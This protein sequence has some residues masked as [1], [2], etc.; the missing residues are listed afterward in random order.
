[1]TKYKG[2]HKAGRST[3]RNLANGSRVDIPDEEVLPGDEKTTYIKVR[4]LAVLLASPIIGLFYVVA[5]PFIAIVEV[6]AIL[7]RKMLRGLFDSLRAFSSFE[8]APNEAHLAGKRRRSES[9]KQGKMK[10]PLRKGRK[11]VYLI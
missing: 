6:V 11:D 7:G 3:Y 1:M 4:V 2:G 5:L 9:E 10:N 8:W